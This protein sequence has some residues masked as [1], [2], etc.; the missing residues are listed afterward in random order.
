MFQRIFIAGLCLE[1]HKMY[2]NGIIFSTEEERWTPSLS[3]SSSTLDFTKRQRKW[4]IVDR[5]TGPNT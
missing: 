4:R 5:T 2:E 1:K 3:M